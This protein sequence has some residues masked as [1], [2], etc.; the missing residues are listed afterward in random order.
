MPDARYFQSAVEAALRYVRQGGIRK[1]VLSRM[2]DV[3]VAQPIDCSAVMNNLRVQNP[4]AYNFSLPLPEGSVLVG[5]SPGLLIRKMRN[6][7]GVIP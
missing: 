6:V 3:D 5:A 4:H 7:S 1:V 2:L